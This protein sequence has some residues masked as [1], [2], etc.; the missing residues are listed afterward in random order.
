MQPN[1]IIIPFDFNY[2]IFNS[3]FI[4][5][6]QHNYN[7]MFRQ[8]FD[9]MTSNFSNFTN[10]V[11]KLPRIDTLILNENNFD[12]NDLLLFK[13]KIK[14]HALNIYFT[15]YNFKLFRNQE[16]N[17]LLENVYNDYFV[18]YNPPLRL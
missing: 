17:Y 14:V 9:V 16:F 13:E 1:R 2:D 10:E 12:R 5:Q 15:C 18:L 6:N 3:T 11:D 7:E 4:N 8:I